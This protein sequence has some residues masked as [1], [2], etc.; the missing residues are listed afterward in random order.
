MANRVRKNDV[1]ATGIEQLTRTEQH[2]RKILADELSPG[3]G[4]SMH[5]EDRVQDVTMVVA[6]WLAIGAIVQLQL[7]QHFSRTKVKIVRDVIALCRRCQFLR[8][9]QGDMKEEYEYGSSHAGFHERGAYCI[10]GMEATGSATGRRSLT[11]PATAD[12]DVAVVENCGLAGS[13]CPLRLVKS[14]QNLVRPDSLDR[15]CGRLV[16]MAN[17]HAHTHRLG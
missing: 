17:L 2:S 10:S 11:D 1:V 13:H 12:H 5:D 3:A 6:H 8:V 15:C 4:G 14:D 7:R 16:T 9:C